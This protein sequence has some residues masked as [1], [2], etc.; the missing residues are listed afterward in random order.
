M[1][2]FEAIDHLCS[3]LKV[4]MTMVVLDDMLADILD[5]G[6][7]IGYFYRR[8]GNGTRYV[9]KQHATGE[10]SNVYYAKTYTI[11]TRIFIA[12]LL[13]FGRV[14]QTCARSS[15]ARM[16]VLY[17]IF[18]GNDLQ[19]FRCDACQ[20]AI[21]HCYQFFIPSFCLCIVTINEAAA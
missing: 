10:I 19:C 1:T 16:D 12:G 17:Y 7:V 14:C 2:S 21:K 13:H 8:Y 4:K 9:C 6:Y 20:T 11:L 5:V 15:N 18:L 3:V